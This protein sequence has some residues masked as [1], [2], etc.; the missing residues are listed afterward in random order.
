MVIIP[1]TKE[2]KKEIAK[3]KRSLVC[4][5][6][7]TVKNSIRNYEEILTRDPRLAGAIRRNE[8][9]E[10][11]H[12]VRN[13]GWHRNPEE[14]VTDTDVNYLR[15]WIETEYGVSSEKNLVAAMDVVANEWRYHPVRDKL[16]SL[17]HDGVSR[18]PYVL[19]HF[20]GAEV[21]DI[22]TAFMTVWLL[23]A[24]ARVFYP[25]TKA[26][27]MLCLT[28]DQ[29][30]GKS[31]FFRFMA[32]KD[33]WFT[34]DIKRLDDE[35]VCR[36]LFGH[37]IV[38]LSEMSAMGKARIEEIK[39][40]I[41]RLSDTYKVPYERHPRDFRRQ[42]VFCGSAN[43]KEFL[44]PDRSG[45]RRFM[46]VE[47]DS[48]KAEVHILEDEATSRAYC[49]Q[50]WAEAMEIFRSGD[51]SLALPKEIEKQLDVYQQDFLPV[52]DRVGMIT[53]YLERT[54]AGSVCSRMIY[55]EAFTEF[56]EPTQNELREISEMVN[57]EIDHGRLT[58]WRRYPN[59]RRYALYGQQRG[60]ERISQ[61]P[62]TFIDVELPAGLFE[63]IPVPADPN[64]LTTTTT[65]RG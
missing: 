47:I 65:T 9:T 19:H 21:T 4:G 54:N 40:F 59:T 24:I 3:L 28:G 39:A 57:S 41:S 2:Q 48:R 27:L 10:R 33:E 14:P 62:E 5:K 17:V 60:W 63:D 29:G 42:C 20:L 58:D 51:Y 36:K 30:A 55:R 35:N 18:I 34:D 8:M 6:D 13:L 7:G 56:R 61:D 15:L 31:S 26:D 22:N 1:P 44:P 49:E 38:E 37:L 12:I 50:V 43:R 53:G 11:N 32:M 16:N 64:P 25:G 46:P 45:N 52:D 23:E